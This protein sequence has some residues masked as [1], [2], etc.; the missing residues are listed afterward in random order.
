MKKI[1]FILICG[2]P[3]LGITQSV[4]PKDKVTLKDSS[5]YIGYIVE[6]T[7]GK[8]I[9]LY[10]AIEMDTLVLDMSDVLRLNKIFNYALIGKKD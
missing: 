8:E 5:E 4:F 2:L 3:V 7:P 10:R 9:K 1:I 6:Q